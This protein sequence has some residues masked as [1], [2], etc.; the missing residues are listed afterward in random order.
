MFQT[1]EDKDEKM[2]L[3]FDESKLTIEIPKNIDDDSCD[4]SFKEKLKPFYTAPITKFTAHSVR[5]ISYGITKKFREKFSFQ[6]FYLAFLIV[7]SYAVLSIDNDH[8]QNTIEFYI[9]F[10]VFCY[11]VE[12]IRQ[13]C[14]YDL[15]F[16]F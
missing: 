14:F 4:L 10:W 6:L 9:L 16:V 12:E 13:V 11:F 5:K 3:F 8:P 7:F 15:C 1:D 2:D